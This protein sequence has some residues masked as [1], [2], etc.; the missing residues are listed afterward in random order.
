MI[1]PTKELL[2]AS[3]ALFAAQQSEFDKQTI[4]FLTRKE[5]LKDRL[6]GFLTRG[7][8]QREKL[9]REGIL[10]WAYTFKTFLPRATSNET[11]FS[12]ALFSPELL[13]EEKPKLL[14]KIVQN[15]QQLVDKKPH[16]FTERKLFNA[17]NAE[18]AE[19]KYF[20]LPSEIAEGH[21]VYLQY[22][23]VFPDQ[24]LDFKLGYNLIIV[25]PSKTKEVMYLPRRYWSDNYRNLYEK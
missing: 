17:V 3:Q 24:I 20:M 19:P 6:H 22:I 7:Y 15:L 2:D 23:E 25:L 8:Y 14:E 13:F 16:S 5:T 10:L 4:N 11:F 12:W 1:E 9:V 18:V 21:M